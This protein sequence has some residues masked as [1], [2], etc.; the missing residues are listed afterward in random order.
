MDWTTFFLSVVVGIGTGVAANLVTSL[1]INV[2][3]P[4]YRDYVYKDVRVDGD[5]TI[6]QS[7][8]PVDGEAL[9]TIWVLSA[10]LEQKAHVVKGIATATHVKDGA[11][12]DVINYEAAGH[13]YNR[14]VSI[15]F[16]N[17]DK[18]R[19]AYSTFL[20]EV[21]GDGTKMKGYRSFYGLRKEIIRAVECTWRR[22]IHE[23][24]CRTHTNTEAA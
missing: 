3:L 7:E 9:S 5:W 10:T 21:K 1:F 11:S 18:A 2:W 14:F 23:A 16:R 12:A 20:L 13:I 15:T 22:G 24:A 8:V 17:K 6:L 19:I 4:A